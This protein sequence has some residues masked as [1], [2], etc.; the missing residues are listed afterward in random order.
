MMLAWWRSASSASG[1]T[2][3]DSR[4]LPMYSSI[5]LTVVTMPSM[6]ELAWAST[7]EMVW[8][9]VSWSENLAVVSR[10]VRS[11]AVASSHR[12]STAGVVNCL[13]GIGG[14]LL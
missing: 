13:L 1:S 7:R 4:G 8:N 9:S 2:P 3:F 10:S 11:A 6:V 5:R 12:A 14:R